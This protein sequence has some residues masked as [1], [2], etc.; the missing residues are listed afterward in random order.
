MIEGTVVN[1]VTSPRAKEAKAVRIGHPG[2]MISVEVEVEKRAEGYHLKVAAF[3]RTSRR[4]ME[5]WVYV[6]EAL[7]RA[8]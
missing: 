7:F 1:R 2:G 6:P 4:I 5:G 3:G 8:G